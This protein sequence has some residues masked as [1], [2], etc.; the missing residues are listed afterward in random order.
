MDNTIINIRFLEWHFMIERG[1]WKPRLLRNTWHY[2]TAWR[3]G[4]FRVYRFFGYTA[5]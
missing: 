1:R 4:R 2:D 5:R 3:D